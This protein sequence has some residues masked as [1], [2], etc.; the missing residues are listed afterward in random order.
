[1]LP[2]GDPLDEPFHYAYASFMAAA[3]RPPAGQEPSVA[4]EVI[5]ASAAMPQ[6]ES[7]GTPTT[8]FRRFLDLPATEQARRRQ[9]AFASS[10]VE[11]TAWAYPN[12]EA[13]QPP[14]A[15]AVVCPFLRLFARAPIDWRL[16]ALRLFG[17]LIASAAVPIVFALLSR[18]VETQTALAATAAYAA[19]PGVGMFVGRFTNDQLALPI[20][21]ALLWLLVE[22][23]ERGLSAAKAAALAGLLTAG[24][25]TKLYFLAFLPVFPLAARLSPASV[26]TRTFVRVGGAT[27]A[28]ALLFLPWALRQR[29]RTG[30]WLGLTETVRAR[31]LGVTAAER[32]REFPGILRPDHFVVL[33][34]TFVWPGTGSWIGAPF[35]V[36]LLLAGT[37]VLLIVSARRPPSRR[38]RPGLAAFGLVLV[39]FAAAQAAHAATFAAV[40]RKAHSPPGAG[41]EGWYA[42]VLAPVLLVTGEAFGRQRRTGFVVLAAGGLLAD[43]FLLFGLLPACYAL[44]FRRHATPWFLPCLRFVVHPSRALDVLNAV[45]LARPGPGWLAAVSIAWLASLSAAIALLV[46]RPEAGGSRSGATPTQTPAG[47]D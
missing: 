3:G 17:V 5:R 21:A 35:P 33:G 32:L 36:S 13:Q 14:L 8:T 42:L 25:W 30:D 28:A 24:L 46:R 37:F 43:V 31:E 40:A 39:S 38:A 4:G 20:A 22:I 23:A 7:T 2:F 9:Q 18:F 11:R 27:L 41:Y 34:R 44:E 26:R 29:A 12:Y 10:P 47:G 16:L 1:M 6:P 19:F 15:Y 45:S